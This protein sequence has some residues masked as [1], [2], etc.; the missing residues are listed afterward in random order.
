[1]KKKL[2]ISLLF[3]LIT[4]GLV[5]QK[6]LPISEAIKN[7][8]ENN[9]DIK[10]SENIEKIAK[11]NSSILNNGYLPNLQLGSDINTNIQNIEIETPSGIS[12]TLDNTQTDNSS[13]V[14]SINYNLIDASGRK[15][16][17]KKSKELY[18]KSKLEVKEII[19]NTLLQL[20]TVYFE[21]GRLAEEEKILKDVLDVSKKRYERKIFEYDYGQTNNLE[22]LN[23][24]VDVNTDSINLLNLSS[25]LNNAKRDLNLIMNIDFNSDLIVDTK[26]NFLTKDELSNL[27]SNGIENNTN[28]LIS[29]K[30]VLYV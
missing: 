1:M 21:V 4:Y 16:N 6:N 15:L 13:A 7:T 18:S 26:I 28:Y 10:I 24:K 19:E 29:K 11:N 25:K 20:F 2:K 23:A 17:Y 9:L 5:A 30:D 14:L 22:V 8:L 27:F 3:F 12:G